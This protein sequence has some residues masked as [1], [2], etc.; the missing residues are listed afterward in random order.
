V[1][2]FVVLDDDFLDCGQLVLRH[3]RQIDHPLAAH[4]ARVILHVGVDYASQF[5]LFE[6][7][8][9]ISFGVCRETQMPQM[10]RRIRISA[11]SSQGPVLCG[12]TPEQV[13]RI[14]DEI[15]PLSEIG[16]KRLYLGVIHAAQNDWFNRLGQTTAASG[17]A[18]GFRRIEDLANELRSLLGAQVDPDGN[19]KWQQFAPQLRHNLGNHLAEVLIGEAIHNEVPTDIL[20]VVPAE[21]R[22]VG[23]GPLEEGQFR[24]GATTGGSLNLVKMTIDMLAEAASRART[25]ESARITHGRG[26]ARRRGRT[27]AS[28]LALDLIPIYCELRRRYPHSGPAPGYSRGGPLPRFILAVFAAIAENN[29]DLESIKDTSIGG[30]FYEYRKSIDARD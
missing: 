8:S 10:S 1:P 27:P 21:G 16:R 25:E 15:G 4:E 28:R 11:N 14:A 17:L 3:F 30:L 5:G 24:I 26:G 29:P 2:L 7:L 12:V 19:D 18:D 6:P 23:G 9:L 13:K 22:V 20:R